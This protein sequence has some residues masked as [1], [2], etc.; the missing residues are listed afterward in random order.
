MGLEKIISLVVVFSHSIFSFSSLTKSV[1]AT[2]KRL[3]FKFQ[4]TKT[5]LDH[6]YH[7]IANGRVDG[8]LYHITMIPHTTR[9]KS[10]I[11]FA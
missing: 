9:V 11:A 2:T 1:F 4:L 7:V 3:C 10:F 8:Y 5:T 6:H